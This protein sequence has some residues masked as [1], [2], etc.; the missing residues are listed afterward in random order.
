MNP[1]DEPLRLITEAQEAY[2][3]VRDYSCMLIKSE[4]MGNQPP[5]ENVMSMRVARSRLA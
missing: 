4:K 1:M 5:V 2:A 3:K